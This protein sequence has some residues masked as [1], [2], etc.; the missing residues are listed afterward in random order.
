MEFPVG[1]GGVTL[2]IVAVI[3]LL[4][5]VPGYTQRSQITETAKY[6]IQQQRESDRKIPMSKD[7]QLRRL[8]NTQRGFSVLFGL[9]VLGA[10]ALWVAAVPN[11]SLLPLA[12]VALALA[13][14]SLLV[15]RAAANQAA[16]LAGALHAR[17]LEVRSKAS[18]AL[19]NSSD[20]REWTPNP[21]PAPLASLPK[22]EPE[23][24]P[25]AEVIQISQPKRVLTGS[26]ID[27]IL[28]RRRAI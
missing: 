21:L 11:Q 27:Q 3:W 18:K 20:R 15:S 8:I 23:A 4:V 25:M 26:E 6:V 10:I 1:L 9:F 22:A 2:V 19:S 5:F 24:A 12:A 14:G 28:A 16:K 7:E 17:R 13:L